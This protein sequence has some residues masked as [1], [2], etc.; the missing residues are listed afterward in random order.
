MICTC[1]GKEGSYSEL[2]MYSVHSMYTWLNTQV[3]QA[4]YQPRSLYILCIG[5]DSP[6]VVTV[7][8]Y[9]VFTIHAHGDG[10]SLSKSSV[11]LSIQRCNSCI[12]YMFPY[13]STCWGTEM[14]Y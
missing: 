12:H 11:P 5:N 9:K 13:N 4:I 1:N 6:L 7:A 3:S 2:C 10:V 14:C 8:I